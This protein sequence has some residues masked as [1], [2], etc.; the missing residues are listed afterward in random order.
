VFK[1]LT[2]PLAPLMA[3][4]FVL[5]ALLVTYLAV[6]IAPSPVFQLLATFWW[7]I[8]LA[9]WIVTD[10]RRRTGVPCF[11]FG[12]FCYLFLPVAVPWYCIWSRGWHGVL[13]MFAIGVLWLAPYI[14]ASM[15]WL[16]WY[17]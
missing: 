14:V 5:S 6:G 2:H 13:T 17:A 11:D 3:F 1:Y 10:A 12:F 4:S 16:A 9:F 15:F 8:L 7:S